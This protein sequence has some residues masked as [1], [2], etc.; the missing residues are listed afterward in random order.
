MSDEEGNEVADIA[1]ALQGSMTLQ[2]MVRS[3]EERKGQ[4]KNK[5]P[6]VDNI[7]TFR[8]SEAVRALIWLGIS[9]DESVSLGHCLALLFGGYLVPTT[10][11][12]CAFVDNTFRFSTRD[13]LRD[14][15]SKLEGNAHCSIAGSKEGVVLLAV[16]RTLSRP[17]YEDGQLADS[18][19]STAIVTSRERGGGEGNRLVRQ[20]RHIVDV[21]VGVDRL[22]V[23]DILRLMKWCN[24][25]EFDDFAMEKEKLRWQSD[26]L[27][28]VLMDEYRKRIREQVREWLATMSWERDDIEFSLNSSG[29]I[30][31]RH[32]EDIIFM[33][34]VQMGVAKDAIPKMS[35]SEIMVDILLELQMVQ[36]SLRSRLAS[37]W[38]DMDPEW[39]CA[40]INDS[41]TMS[42][43]FETLDIFGEAKDGTQPT[44][45]LGKIRDDVARGY[46]DIAAEATDFLAKLMTSDLQGPVMDI[47]FSPQWESDGD[48]MNTCT[49]TLRDYFNDLKQWL[50]S[51]E[52]TRLAKR[53]IDFL[54][55][56]Y[57]TSAFSE[58]FNGVPFTDAQ[59]MP[60]RLVK[61][62]LIL[63]DF[64]GFVEKQ[65]EATGLKAHAEGCLEL[66][67]VMASILESHSEEDISDDVLE[68]SAVLGAEYV[69]AAVMYMVTRKYGREDRWQRKRWQEAVNASLNAEKETPCSMDIDLSHLIEAELIDNLSMMKG[70]ERTLEEQAGM[71][72]TSLS[73]ADGDWEGPIL[74]GETEKEFIFAINRGFW[75]E[76]HSLQDKAVNVANAVESVTSKC[77]GLVDALTDVMCCLSQSNEIVRD[78]DVFVSAVLGVTDGEDVDLASLGSFSY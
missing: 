10:S 60:A 12:V 75:G 34:N 44:F 18:I 35:T 50:P 21:I 5:E 17:E 73:P 72:I 62:M 70:E 14:A 42:G 47:V 28:K 20:V 2:S 25:S 51:C 66:L 38:E 45:V 57:V 37:D 61:D 40:I 55:E 63:L 49:A 24:E 9:A 7:D 69:R 67:L 71:L 11:K 58:K 13:E 26:K 33:I 48:L 41:C 22:P 3:Y 56:M 77:I 65:M 19:I 43:Y 6:S 1:Y 59:A 23:H 4:L 54:L 15:L 76:I 16:R 74:D 27:E 32:P 78:D 64:F 30:V 68:L 29:N 46:L 52:F 39:L 53:S 36:I 31:S 8:G